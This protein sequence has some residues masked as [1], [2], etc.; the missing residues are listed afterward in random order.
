MKSK[1]NSAQ[2]ETNQK[3]SSAQKDIKEIIVN[4]KSNAK[5]GSEK[6]NKKSSASVA[7]SMY[8]SPV[9]AVRSN[10][11]SSGG[12]DSTGINSEFQE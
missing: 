8:S 11:Y 1:K 7:A 10:A 6:K 5:K 12:V 9:N 4:D 3:N 2:N